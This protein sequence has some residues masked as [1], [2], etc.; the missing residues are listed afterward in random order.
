LNGIH[1]QFLQSYGNIG[2]NQ[3]CVWEGL[4]SGGDPQSHTYTWTTGGSWDTW[5]GALEED[6]AWATHWAGHGNTTGWYELTLTVTDAYGNSGSATT[7]GAVNL[8]W[9]PN[10]H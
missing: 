5:N 9:N 1:V 10:C 2:V 6:Y 3:S 4:A 7:S 8:Y